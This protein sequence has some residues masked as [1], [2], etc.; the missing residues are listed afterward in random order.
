[1]SERHRVAI[2]GSGNVSEMHFRGYLDRPDRVELVAAVDPSPERRAWVTE[3]FGIRDTYASIAE[4]VAGTDVEVASVCTPSTVRLEAVRELAAAG[5][6]LL[7]EKPMADD[8]DEARAIVR[9]AADAGV[10]LAVDQNF[11]DHYA[12]GLA[13]DAIRAGRIGRVLGI[14]QSELMWREVAGWRAEARHHALAVMGVHWFDG[15]RYLIDGDADTISAVIF[16]H[17][18]MATAGETDA[19]VQVRF[20]EV[21]VNYTQSFA[22][23]VERVETIVLGEAGTLRLSYDALEVH[24]A[25]GVETTTNPAAGSGKPI[26]AYRSL[27]RLLDAIEA[28]TEPEN[29]GADNLKT[30]SLLF[31]A[32]ESA[33]TGAPVTLTGGLL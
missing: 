23:R 20:G 19:F 15:F 7:V 3:T 12:F 28:G 24:T 18:A 21:P 29:S 22:S 11:R 26:S 4:L 27:E 25:D 8:M 9:T 1:M 5:K 16:T 14:D 32:Y 17:P 13:R 10:L 33:R 31:G 6:H 30:L 2:V